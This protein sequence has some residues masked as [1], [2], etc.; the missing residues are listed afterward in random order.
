MLNYCNV[1]LQ[2][3]VCLN[4]LYD[5]ELNRQFLSDSVSELSFF[6]V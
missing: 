1:E 3:Q 6:S 5:D 4:K 2:R